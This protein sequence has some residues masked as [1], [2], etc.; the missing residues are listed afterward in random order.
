MEIPK[1]S[2]KNYLRCIKDVD[3]NIEDLD[4]FTISFLNSC[5]VYLHGQ[6]KEDFLG[7]TDGLEVNG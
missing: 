7:K 6:T 3:E 2:Q 5:M 1:D 4:L